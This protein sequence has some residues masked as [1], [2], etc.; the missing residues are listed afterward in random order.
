METVSLAYPEP[1]NPHYA[2]LKIRAFR[3]GKFMTEGRE[4]FS[5]EIR[6]DDS[7]RQALAAL[8]ANSAGNGGL[9]NVTLA[10]QELT[11]DGTLWPSV[12]EAISD[13]DLGAYFGW[14]V[15]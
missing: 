2:I 13:F 10:G 7:L 5:F 4:E 15:V 3:L 11:L 12:L 14:S 1:T 8:K 9:A 6:D